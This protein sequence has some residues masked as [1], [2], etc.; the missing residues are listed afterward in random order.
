M[1]EC[2]F[3]IIEK[4]KYLIHISSPNRYIYL[5]TNIHLLCR[6]KYFKIHMFKNIKR[7]V[8]AEVT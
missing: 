5:R 4:L 1:N 8:S 3:N 6:Y 2:K 7:S